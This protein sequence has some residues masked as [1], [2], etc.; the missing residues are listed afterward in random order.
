MW[1]NEE[2]DFEVQPHK[3][4]LDTTLGKYNDINEK[5]NFFMNFV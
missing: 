2:E 3:T 1:F 4:D 5:L